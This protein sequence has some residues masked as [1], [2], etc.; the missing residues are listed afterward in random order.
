MQ[1]GPHIIK[2]GLHV[3]SAVWGM[4]Q[5]TSAWNKEKQLEEAEALSMTHLEK[6]MKTRR[7]EFAHQFERPRDKDGDMTFEDVWSNNYEETMEK[8]AEDT[9]CVTHR[10]RQM[11]KK[12]FVAIKRD[13]EWEDEYNNKCKT[14]K[15]KAFRQKYPEDEVGIALDHKPLVQLLLHSCETQPPVDDYWI[16][17]PE[18]E[19]LWYE[20]FEDDIQHVKK[21]RQVYDDLVAQYGKHKS[22]ADY[23]G[24]E[25]FEKG[26]S[27]YH[28]A[29]REKKIDLLK[30]LVNH[31]NRPDTTTDVT[32]STDVNAM[33]A[34][35]PLK[36]N[37]VEQHCTALHLA[38]MDNLPSFV[39]VLLKHPAVDVNAQTSKNKETALHLCVYYMIDSYE[40][41]KQIVD[42]LLNHTKI[43]PFT[44]DGHVKNGNPYPL[45][46]L[47]NQRTKVYGSGKLGFSQ[48]SKKFI[49]TERR[50][51]QGIY[52][53]LY[54]HK[55]RKRAKAQQEVKLNEKSASVV[56]KKAT[57]GR[58]EIVDNESAPNSIG[59]DEA[60]PAGAATVGEINTG[61][62]KKEQNKPKIS[63]TQKK[64]DKK[65]NRKIRRQQQLRE[66][67]GK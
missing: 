60:Y 18:P 24:S 56:G 58:I 5:Q 39:E 31:A 36:I 57:I 16:Y 50:K 66:Q 51:S 29:V 59:A 67:A 19:R 32:A 44:R 46:W 25:S 64:K 43:K 48:K 65:K 1:V 61:D 26:E 49:E 34:T 45:E 9:N 35:F 37:G 10:D 41:K 13:G 62:A 3:G 7:K 15:C 38:V 11:F 30:F 63:K 17:W 55:L 8:F 28:Y 27:I 33:T 42:L 14:K 4:M 12:M 6:Y 52:D 53:S 54:N 40:F 47:S 20:I 21:K 23:V 2:A 22:L